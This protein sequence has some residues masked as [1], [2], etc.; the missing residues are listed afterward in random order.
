MK[1]GD[2]IFYVLHLN[3]TIQYYFQFKV[4]LYRKES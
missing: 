4:S 1:D 2:K 3:C